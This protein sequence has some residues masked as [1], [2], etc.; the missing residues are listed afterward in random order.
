MEVDN[1]P[2]ST[3][4]MHRKYFYKRTRKGNIVR[5][6]NDK[7]LRSDSGC[8]FLKGELVSSETLRSFV[9]QAPHQQILLIDTNIRL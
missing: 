1:N 2:D 9:S 8:G 6:V 7:Y 3:E 5:I 4:N